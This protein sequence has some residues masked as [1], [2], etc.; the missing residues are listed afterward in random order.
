MKKKSPIRSPIRICLADDH[1]IVRDGLHMIL[2]AQPDFQVVGLASNGREAVQLVRKSKPQVLVIDIAMPEL[3]GI[4]ATRQILLLAPA[5]RVVILSMHAT[6]EHIFRALEAGAQGYVLKESAGKEVVA[7]VRMVMTGHRFLSQRISDT[8]T[9]DYL[10][11]R[12][13]P[14]ESPLE[15]LSSREREVL[16]LVVEG[17]S[18]KEIADSLHLSPKSV[19]TYRSR[20][21][22]K[23][24]I[25]DVPALVKFA[26]EHGLT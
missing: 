24:D 11:N 1:A 26:I 4:D 12:E 6:S 9:L 14:T 5:T 10:R 17:K 18:S 23:L 21:M 3:N 22:M 7:A 25:H 2:D 8:M 19:D 15:R 20:L 16:Q 13:H